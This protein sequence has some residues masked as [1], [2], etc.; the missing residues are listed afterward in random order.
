M[1]ITRGKRTHTRKPFDPPGGSATESCIERN[2]S[3]L[4]AYS[5]NRTFYPDKASTFRPYRT[6]S[7]MQAIPWPDCVLS[8][9]LTPG[10][11]AGAKDIRQSILSL[12]ISCCALF[13]GSALPMTDF[14]IMYH[15]DPVYI[16]REICS[17]AGRSFI[18]ISGSG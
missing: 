13:L 17:C 2:S 8:C 16:G 3:L 12:S 4:L 7:F 18:P 6:H 11:N 9:S 15:P 5:R 10:I 1:S 14:R